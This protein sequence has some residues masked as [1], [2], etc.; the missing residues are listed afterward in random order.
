MNDKEWNE[1]IIEHNKK[2]K[3]IGADKIDSYESFLI[4]QKN[5]LRL[6]KI[7]SL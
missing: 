4:W 3:E 5:I 6:K 1:F 7:N 2:L